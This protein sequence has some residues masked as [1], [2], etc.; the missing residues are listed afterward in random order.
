MPALPACLLLGPVKHCTG[1]ANPPPAPLYAHR[2][3]PDGLFGE[4]VVAAMAG[5]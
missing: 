3:T 4:P 2:P 5:D 1:D